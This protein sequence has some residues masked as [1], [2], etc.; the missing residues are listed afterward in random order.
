[1]AAFTEPMNPAPMPVFE[2][3]DDRPRVSAAVAESEVFA[4]Q[5]NIGEDTLN[6]EI[7]APSGVTVRIHLNDGYVTEVTVP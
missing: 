7:D 6:I 4:H 2:D 1:M 5:S 3:D